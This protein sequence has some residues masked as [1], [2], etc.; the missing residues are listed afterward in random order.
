M[1]V[2]CAF[3]GQPKLLRGSSVVAACSYENVF[4]ISIC[5]PAAADVDS[6]KKGKGP[7]TE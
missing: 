1:A 2:H 3:G 6:T 4:M 5:V 7:F